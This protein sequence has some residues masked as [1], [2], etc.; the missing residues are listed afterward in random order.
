MIRVLVL[1][2]L[3]LSCSVA[4]AHPLAPSSVRLVERADGTIEQRF[5]TPS[6]RVI[7]GEL[8]PELPAGCRVLSAHS[9]G[10]VETA[11]AW[12]VV[13][14]MVCD[15]GLSGR[16][17]AIRAL[18][19]ASTDVVWQVTL[20]DGTSAQG[21]LHGIRDRFEV[22]G[23][24][25]RAS[26][27]VEY[28]GLG[29]L[30]LVTGL[31]HVLFVLSLLFV[32]SGRRA[33]ILAVTAFTVGHSASLALA[34]YGLVRAPRAPVEIAIAVSLLFLATTLVR[35]AGKAGTGLIARWPALLPAL[36]GLVHGL[37]FA[38]VLVDA[39]LSPAA[40]PVA[41]FGFNVGIELA[42]LGILAAGVALGASFRKLGSFLPLQGR[43]VAAYGVGS[44]AAMW[45]IERGL[46]F[47]I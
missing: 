20:A 47:M 23:S 2:S 11:D 32:L 6:V 1:F 28:L 31:D 17:V 12:E 21:L 10:F 16:T 33:L 26:A 25:R 9:T 3:L 37:G 30:H 43:V 36:F 34:S 44:I 14:R 15:G 40:T 5:R 13:T 27:F 4:G 19:S 8:V 41:L 42:Q 29:A 22:P 24:R 39:G 7:G 46:Q 45:V 38:T 18:R 35:G